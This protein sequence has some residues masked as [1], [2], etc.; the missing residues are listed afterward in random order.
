MHAGNAACE[1]ASRRE[2]AGGIGVGGAGHAV[3]GGSGGGGGREV[4]SAGRGSTASGVCAS[5]PVSLQAQCGAGWRGG[6]AEG[7][8]ETAEKEEE[9][10]Q[11]PGGPGRKASPAYC[12]KV[13]PGA[14]RNY[15]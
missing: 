2:G 11:G 12:Q 15:G 3:V 7:G 9:G 1:S 8:A 13:F 10:G 5:V 6:G 4:G 14:R